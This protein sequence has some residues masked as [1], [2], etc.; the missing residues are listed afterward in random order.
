M[1]SY[2]F[3]R[4]TLAD[5]PALLEFLN[6]HW[7][8]RHPLVNLPD[9]FTYYYQDGD[10]Q[11]QELN[12]ALCLAGEQLAAVCGFIPTSQ[13]GEEIWISIWC[14]DR[15][16]KGSGLELMA[17]M[18]PLTGAARM[19]CNN[20]RPGTIPFYEF[21]GYTGG[22]IDHYYRLAPRDSYRLARVADP[23]FP[24]VGGSGQL[25]PFA[26]FEELKTAYTPPAAG[27]CH[28]AK[29]LWYLQRR[30]FNYPRQRYLAYGGFFGGRCPLLFFLRRAEACGSAALRLV[31]LVG[32]LSL[33]PQFGAAID[34]LLQAQQAEYIDCYCWGPDPRL[35]AR[36]GFTPRPAGS[37]DI[38][39]HYL[40]PPLIENVEYYFFTSDP[41][42]YLLFRAD[43][44]QDRPNLP[45]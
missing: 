43:G 1:S 35:M 30:Y 6:T 7:G 32:D 29:D 23:A 34:R 36:A 3:R 44:D 11:R 9:Y 24:P 25:R 12:F 19:S 38:I 8:A 5:K 17:Q 39:P 13:T 20:I 18:L 42:D 21:L 40:D 31:D 10:P 22:R 15:K 37:D 28:P 27:G 14:A 16:A 45:C 2:T 41:K 33:L 4:A 26:G